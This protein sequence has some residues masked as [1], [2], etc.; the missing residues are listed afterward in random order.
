MPD[1]VSYVRD[2]AIKMIE[3]G[4]YSISADPISTLSGINFDIPVG[5]YFSQSDIREM[6]LGLDERSCLGRLAKAAAI[7]ERNYSGVELKFGEVWQ[8]MLATILLD[9]MRENPGLKNDPSYLEE[10]LLYEEPHAVIVVH[11]KQYDPLSK[12]AGFEIAHP[13]IENLPLWEGITASYMVSESQLQENPAERLKILEEAEK[14][15]PGTTLVRENMINPLVR[16]GRNDEM[17]ENLNW[18]IERRPCARNLYAHYVLTE[19]EESNQR[20]I[21]TYSE[22]IISHILGG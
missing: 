14:I 4:A 6:N 17:V 22:K 11:G 8:D 5:T 7:V 2:L 10:I 13:R 9:R 16:L 15:C 21:K 19:N 20:L 12:Q 3:N 18:V 1:K